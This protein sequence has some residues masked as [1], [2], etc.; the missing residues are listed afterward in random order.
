MTQIMQY[1]RD[2]PVSEDRKLARKIKAQS[3]RYI[4]IS[5]KLYR[6]SFSGLY[7]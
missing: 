1:L 5:G 7:M 6:K 4:M 2:G 3:V